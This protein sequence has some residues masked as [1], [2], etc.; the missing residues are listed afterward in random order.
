M[1]YQ[2]HHYA[3][4]KCL[5][6]IYLSNEFLFYIGDSVDID[7]I[8]LVEADWN[9]S[10][11]PTTEYITI[12]LPQSVDLVSLSLFNSV[13]SKISDLPLPAVD[14]I[15]VPVSDLQNGLYYIN[16][17][18]KKETKSKSFVLH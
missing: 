17:Q 7:D 16:Y 9:I 10:P 6:A 15:T 2:N 13:G 18:S 8:E 11:N 12:T 1:H 4:Q 3:N 5:I 14:Q